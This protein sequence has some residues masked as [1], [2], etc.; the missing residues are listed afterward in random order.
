[1]KQEVDKDWI[2]SPSQLCRSRPV[3]KLFHVLNNCCRAVAHV[4]AIDMGEERVVAWPKHRKLGGPFQA[5][6]YSGA[7]TKKKTRTKKNNNNKTKSLN[8]F[9]S[10]TTI[11]TPG[12]LAINMATI[13][14]DQPPIL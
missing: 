2:Y 10:R 3:R 4:E 11:W 8:I 9:P 14:A 5:F 6:R 1:M 13:K 12:A 7:R